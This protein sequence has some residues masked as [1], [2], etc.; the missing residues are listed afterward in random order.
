VTFAFTDIEG[1]TRRWERNRTAMQ[2]A[3]RRHDALMR[4]AII[5]HGG[6]VFKTVGDAFCAAFWRPE[7]A[8]AAMLA[9]QRALS[10]E[11][12][13]AIDGLRVRAALHTGTAD[14]RESD[15][16]GPTVNRVARL[17]AIGHGG[18]VL[19]SGVTSELV[20]AALPAQASLRDL[21]EHRLKDLAQLERV[22][23]LLAPGLATE[24]PP[25][26]SLDAR[27]NNLPLQ[28]TSFVGRE[29]E[30]ADIASLLAAHREVTLVGSGG[31]GKTR[32]SLQVAENL[33]DA[34]GDGVWFIE[35]APLGSGD[36]IPSTVAQP[37]GI[38]LPRSGDP[39]E[40][41][42][43]SLEKKHALLVFDNCEH[44]VEP[45]ARTVSALL[46]GCPKIKVL[47]SSRQGL[48]IA[49]E[50]TYRIPSLGVPSDAVAATFAAADAELYAATT[51]FVER[52]HAADSRFSLTDENAAPVAEI[53]RRLDGIPLAIELAAARVTI[54]SPRQLQERLDERFR[55]L[56]HGRRDVLPRQQTLRALIDWSY[57]LLD[58]RE[59][60]L[61]RRLGIFTNGFTLEAAVAV[62]GSDGFDEFDAFDVLASL[63]EK[64]LV[65]SE[66]SGDAL[67]YRML[68]STLLYAREKL[69]DAGESAVCAARRA[70]HLRHRFL[71][72]RERFEITARQS[73]L[74]QLLAVELEDVRAAL[75]W[76]SG[77]EEAL[78][79]AELLGGVG[80]TWERAGLGNEG[81]TRAESALAVLPA[82]EPGLRS[83]LG[84]VVSHNAVTTGLMARALE[85][86]SEAVAD[87]RAS[88]DGAVLAE[89]LGASATC[90]VR[91]GLLDVAE[92]ELAEAEAIAGLPAVQTLQL[93]SCRATVLLARRD[94]SAAAQVF[95]RL[96]EAHRSLGNVHSEQRNLL[97]LAETEHARGQ[98]RRAI[99]LAHE[100]L[101][102]LRT[103][104]NRGL[105]MTVLTNLAGYLVAV[106]ELSGSAAI[107]REAIREAAPRDP[108][109]AYIAYSMEHLA[110]AL[111]LAT[112]LPR[113]ATIAGYAG[114]AIRG[115]GDG[116]QFTE[117]MSRD[118]LTNILSD[119]LAPQD[120]ARL[121]AEGAALVP[122]AAVALALR[123]P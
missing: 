123:E 115:H 9:A 101:P 121:V 85:A 116:R 39:V 109:H 87:A 67:R 33:L 78:L 48:G 5:D 49:G 17:L 105:L 117:T 90:A 122:E 95:E 112:E 93:L 2:E 53:C 104:S 70:R 86:T 57:D 23:Q 92:A 31:I 4:T 82:S 59:R 35:L 84:A 80:T 62:G 96:R 51:L 38:T 44:L 24:F 30:L 3:L 118:R 91:S 111:A 108:E 83:R 63:V 103:G 99:Q 68:E 74:D 79:G 98:T 36:Y 11:D 13:S 26:R 56:T 119:G 64:S 8:V 37:L 32:A 10:I 102:G 75:D 81:R 6:Y 34:W 42:V 88:G 7:E 15:Y 20:Q 89:A 100:A 76:A 29:T 114:A 113:A 45:V 94:F 1:S 43:R 41:L 69:A 25:L 65:L 22:R 14:E 28:L 16:F 52:A 58:Q 21:G 71:A 46:R 72:E 73:G 77:N 12:F 120:L 107:A 106:D 47:A 27:P 66:P 54:L 50:T 110:L 40:N 61:F 97:N 19:V 60:M 18:Q 55:V